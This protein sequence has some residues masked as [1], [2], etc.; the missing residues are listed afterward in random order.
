METLIAEPKKKKKA[1]AKKTGSNKDIA[2]SYNKFKEFEGRQYTGMKVGRSHKWNYEAGI[3]KETK[4]TPDEWEIS[5]SVTKHR[6]GKAPEGSG[7]PVGTE[8]NWYIMANQ[9]VKKLDANT[10]STAMSGFKFK[11]AHKRADKDKW[12]LSEHTQ[13]KHMVKILQDFAGQLQKEIESEKPIR[14]PGLGKLPSL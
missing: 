4:I 13:K 8:Y 2:A 14:K 12:S 3:W 11:L 7:A 1:P 5:F 10:Y 9:N 6:V